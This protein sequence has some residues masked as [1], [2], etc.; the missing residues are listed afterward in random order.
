MAEQGLTHERLATMAGVPRSSLSEWLSGEAKK[1]PPA[2]FLRD[3]FRAARLS[4][5]IYL[6]SA[7]EQW[8]EAQRKKSAV[9]RDRL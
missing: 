1:C 5:S 9:N 2:D 7:C 8:T 3:I 4:L 6:D